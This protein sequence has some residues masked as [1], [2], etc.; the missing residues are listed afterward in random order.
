MIVA[1]ALWAPQPVVRAVLIASNGTIQCSIVVPSSAIEPETFAARELAA[2]LEKVTGARPEIRQEPTEGTNL[3]VGRSPYAISLLSDFDLNE[4]GADGVVVRAI[5][6][7]LVITGGVP[8]GV[9]NAVYVFLEDVLGC[10]WWTPEVEHVPLQPTVDVSGV[11]IKYVPPFRFRYIS[12]EGASDI[13][14]RYRIRNNGADSKFDPDGESITRFLLPSAEHFTAHPEWYMYDPEDGEP[15]KKYTFSFGLEQ[16]KED[17]EKLA[18]ARE[19]RR[20]PYQPCMTSEGAMVTAANTALERL[21]TEYANLTNPLKVFW[22]VQQDGKW[23]CRCANC[24]RMRDAEGSDS[25]SWILFL[26]YVAERIEKNYPDV[27]VG[28]HAYLHTIQ[29]PAS[30]RPRDNVLVYMAALDRD[31]KLS[32][33]ELVEGEYVKRWCE[34]AKQVWVWDYDTNFRNYIKPHPNHLDMARTI[35]FCRDAGTQGMRIQGAM[36]RLSDLVYMRNW[37][38]AQMAWNPDKDPDALRAEFLNGYYGAAGPVLGRYITVLDEIIHRGKGTFLSCYAGSTEGWLGLEDLI[39]LTKIM[40]EATAA[41]ADDELLASRIRDARMSIDV[42]WLDRYDALKTEAAKKNLEFLGP[43]DP[44]A[45]VAQ[46][47]KIQD[48]VGHYKERNEFPE[49]VRHLRSLHAPPVA[50]EASSKDAES[51]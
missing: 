7:D 16:L 2:Y 13:P 26:N 37:V 50:P 28:M 4:L 6:S 10:R 32:F 11:N 49:Y 14:F 46:L 40:N 5:G 17:P 36:G 21:E 25:A 22:V 29:P 20:L 15:D 30:V 8:R 31:H 33:G 1:C 47:A 44:A 35:R 43:E 19:H 38:N 41:V 34:L 12:S 39:S 18:V 51:Y 45:Y 24:G 9:R 23:M 3:H 27:L 42:V 48:T